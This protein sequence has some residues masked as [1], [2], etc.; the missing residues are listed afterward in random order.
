MIVITLPAYNEE[1]TIGRVLDDIKKVMKG[2]KYKIL[3]VDD[4]SSDNTAKIAKSKGAKVVSHIVNRGLAMAFKTEMKKCLEMKA[5]TIV[6]F[7]ADGQYEAKEIPLLLKEHNKGHNLV[8]GSRFMGRIESM[9]FMKRIG[10]QAFSHVLSH[11]THQRITDGQTG[12][13][14]FGP[15]V[16]RLPMVGCHTYTQQQI[17]DAAEEGF[18]IKEVPI[19]FYKRDG[20]SHLVRTPIH[21]AILA[22]I[23]LFRVYRDYKPLKFFGGVGLGFLFLG[24]VLAGIFLNIHFTTG[25]QGHIPSM[26]LMMLLIMTGLQ[27]MLFGFLADMRRR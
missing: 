12:F 16:A 7:D 26:I 11:L 13:R 20:K 2:G 19:T 4:G 1:K 25:I 18:S 8:L 14:V 27:V 15:E 3:V 23:T 5:D 21:Y 10:N 9:P 6:H 24:L 22:W 17:I